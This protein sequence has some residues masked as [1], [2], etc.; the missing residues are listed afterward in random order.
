MREVALTPEAQGPRSCQLQLRS[1]G[2]YVCHV[3]RLSIVRFRYW[4]VELGEFLY[5][6]LSLSS[7][8]LN[9]ISAIQ[10]RTLLSRW[11][12]YS[13]ISLQLCTLWLLLSG[14][15]ALNHS[16]VVVL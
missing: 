3:G 7:A 13:A 11:A 10:A 4:W 8:L 16:P 5:I 6:I 9:T 12:T 2:P 14:V 15:M 1:G